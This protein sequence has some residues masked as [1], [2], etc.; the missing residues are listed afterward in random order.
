[1]K[2][3]FVLSFVVFSAQVELSGFVLISEQKIAVR[4]GG[5]GGG[6]TSGLTHTPINIPG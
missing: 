6:L 4:G 2:A 3:N 1:M 5:G